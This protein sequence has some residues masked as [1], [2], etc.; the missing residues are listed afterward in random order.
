MSGFITA[1]TDAELWLLGAAVASID[2]DETKGEAMH[3]RTTLGRRQWIIEADTGQMVLEVD[4]PELTETCGPL[5]LSERIR[6]FGDM[7]DDDTLVLSLA[8]DRTVVATSGDATAAIDLVAT[9]AE[10][11]PW[12]F[13]RDASVTVG[14][15]AFLGMLWSA[16][17]LPSGLT[18]GPYPM[19]PMW[20]QVGDGWL[21]LHVDWSD[22]LPSRSTYR[23]RT[24]R[25]DGDATVAVPH[26]LLES[27]LRK[28]PDFDGVDDPTELVIDIGTVGDRPAMQ[29]RADRWQLTLWLV[30]PLVNRWQ[31][32]VDDELGE[33]RVLERGRGTWTIGGFQRDVVLQLHHGHPDVVRV[34]AA[35]LGPVEETLDL[36][37]E[38]SALNAASS[39]VRF[40]LEEGA[41]HAAADVPC[42]ALG[43]LADMVRAVGHA[44]DAYAPMLALL[45][46]ST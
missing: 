21:G 5:A 25:H 36:L 40:W 26:H 34:S 14:F 33:L 1:V 6:R 31:G 32:K 22:F 8:D 16:R 27:F 18:D 17:C 42:T 44:A 28:V 46:P 41:V 13:Q 10:P 37:R 11:E 45:G 3:L 43:T 24:T 39:G 12:D 9:D 7:F 29:V 4:D 38:L 19:P 2:V 30:Q 23:I 15:R 35:L 20:L